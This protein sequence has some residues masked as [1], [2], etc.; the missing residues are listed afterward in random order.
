MKVLHLFNE[1]NFSGAEIMYANAAPLFQS[2]GIEMLAFS[3]GKNYGDFVAQFEK[4]NIKTFHK[5]IG[6]AKIISLKSIQYYF[7]FY[8]FLKNEEIDVLHIHRNNLYIAS[9]CSR[10]AGVRTIKTMH[11]VFKNR[12]ITYPF[13]YL[14]RMIA[15]KFLNVTTQSIS[16]S[17]YENE[18]LYYKNP[19]KLINNW[20][21]CNHFFKAQDNLEKKLFRNKIGISESAFVIISVGMCTEIKNHSEI[22]KSLS[23]VNQKIDCLYLHLGTGCTESLERELTNETGLNEKILFLGNRINVRDYLI[24]SDIFIMPSKFE[25]LGNA[26]IEAM[27]CGLPSILYDVP[28]LRDLITNADNG[29]LIES[30]YN[31]LAEKIIQFYDNPSLAKEKGNS[32]NRHVLQYYSVNKNVEEIIKLYNN[33]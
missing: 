20:Y 4:N 8:K 2:Q 18:L 17:V 16:K 12:K 10:L 13:G 29:F 7:R 6:N 11:N 32:A 26:C 3:T 15:R 27:A 33:L 28:G 25:G 5:P 1:I 22:I 21:D 9:I 30:D 14:H 31:L 23:I 24:A 19:S